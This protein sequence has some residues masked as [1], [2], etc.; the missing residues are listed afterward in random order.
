MTPSTAA[1]IRAWNRTQQR[2]RLAYYAD[3]SGGALERNRVDAARIRR[4][5]AYRRA[6]QRAANERRK[7]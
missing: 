2:T 7:P 3:P 5:R 6:E 4:V 1:L